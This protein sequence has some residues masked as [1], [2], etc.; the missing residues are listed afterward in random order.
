MIYTDTQGEE[1]SVAVWQRQPNTKFFY[2]DTRNL[3]HNDSTTDLNTIDSRQI[4]ELIDFNNSDGKIT[5]ACQVRKNNISDDLNGNSN[6]FERLDRNPEKLAAR[7]CSEP[8]KG[9]LV[10]ES[11][12][13]KNLNSSLCPLV[14]TNVTEKMSSNLRESINLDQTEENS[15]VPCHTSDYLGT[16]KK[17][18]QSNGRPIELI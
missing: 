10:R 3:K 14:H 8:Q 16:S 13:L 18:E 7:L 4:K 9:D 12:N 2:F 15:D 11:E 5:T 17:S 1:C 6:E